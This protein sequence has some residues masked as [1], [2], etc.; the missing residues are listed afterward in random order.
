MATF[1]NSYARRKSSGQ[2]DRRP[3]YHLPV[4]S[5]LSHKLAIE[6]YLTYKGA[7]L[8]RV[9]L[10]FF[11]VCA[12]VE[13]LLLRVLLLFLFISSINY[14]LLCNKLSPNVQI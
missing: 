5:Q 13:Y 10:W 8:Y 7:H 6:I 9:W 1:N 11:K 2:G 4:Q 12:P 14:L 3:K